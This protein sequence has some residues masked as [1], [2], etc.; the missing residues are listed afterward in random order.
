MLATVDLVPP[1]IHL[2]LATHSSKNSNAHFTR[3]GHEGII[4]IA[5]KEKQASRPH[6]RKEPKRAEGHS[7]LPKPQP[8]SLLSPSNADEAT[9]IGRL[10][11]CS[12]KIHL[13]L[14]G[15][16]LQLVFTFTVSL[17]IGRGGQCNIRSWRNGG[18]P[19]HLRK[20]K[21]ANPHLL[22]LP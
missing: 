18:P 8:S 3:Q 12:V 10:R 21:H 17:V 20:S 1:P 14:S 4:P 16:S 7:L 22:Q 15:T 19:E 2:C 6:T 9:R 11:N 13:S 5:T